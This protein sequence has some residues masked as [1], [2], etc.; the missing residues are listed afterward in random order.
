MT[1]IL[2]ISESRGAI[3]F[4]LGNFIASRVILLAGLKSIVFSVS[5]RLPD[6]SSVDPVDSS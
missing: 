4:G 3:G 1:R 2:A 6:R 5:I